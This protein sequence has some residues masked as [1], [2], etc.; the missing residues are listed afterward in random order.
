MLIAGF[1][2]EVHLFAD[3]PRGR[4]L[5]VESGRLRR[6]VG[7]APIGNGHDIRRPG[8]RMRERGE[9]SCE[10]TTTRKTLGPETLP[11]DPNAGHDDVA[12]GE[13]HAHGDASHLAR[14][15]RTSN[16]VP[17][18]LDLRPRP[19]SSFSDRLSEDLRS[20]EDEL[21]LRSLQRNVSLDCCEKGTGL[22]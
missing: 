9:Q 10:R 11:E 5:V 2:R 16:L 1:E 6:I 14:S 12:A 4:I 19:H 3:M 17:L 18:L 21:L 7:P 8:P 20:V 13:H 22:R 15:R